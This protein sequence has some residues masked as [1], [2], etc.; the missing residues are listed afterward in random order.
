MKKI[1][2]VGVEGSGKTVLMAAMGDKYKSP[3]ANGYFMLPQNHETFAF[4]TREA[5][6]MRNGMWPIATATGTFRR[7]DWCLMRKKSERSAPEHICEITFADFAGE[8]YR[9]AFGN[10]EHGDAGPAIEESVSQVKEHVFNSDVLIVLVNLAEVIYGSHSDA[11][12]IEMLWLTQ[13]MFRQ[14]NKNGKRQSIALV[15]TQADAYSETI[16]ACGGLRGVLSKYLPQVYAGYSNRISLFAVSAVSKTIPA[17][18]GSGF[19][20]PAGDFESSGLDVV[21]NWIVK[22][23]KDNVGVLR[24]SRLNCILLLIAIV[25]IV[26]GCLFIGYK[27]VDQYRQ[28]RESSERLKRNHEQKQQELIETEQSAKQFLSLYST[29]HLGAAGKLLHRLSNCI[30]QNDKIIAPRCCELNNILATNVLMTAANMYFDGDGCSKDIGQAVCCFV[31]ASNM[32]NVVA[33]RR[34]AEICLL[35]DSDNRYTAKR[36]FDEIPWIM[37]KVLGLGFSDDDRKQLKQIA[38][39]LYREAAE[40][41]DAEAQFQLSKCYETGNLG[42]P[43][44]HAKSV[45]WLKRAAKHGHVAAN[46]L[47]NKK[48]I[49]R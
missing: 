24:L 22:I 31:L 14:A 36:K 44:D 49:T 47:L 43:I 5:D 15:F 34:I 32:G 38:G 10:E 19:P 1:A 25:G 23:A 21:L 9:I 41:G 39:S 2:I 12:T 42:I 17:P 45:L 27:Q 18:D 29:G 30:Y 37:H 33:S 28:R 6:R 3:D 20:V 26:Y 7:L 48:G 35:Y 46:D 13:D 8:I 11:R 16:T 40:N 4:Y